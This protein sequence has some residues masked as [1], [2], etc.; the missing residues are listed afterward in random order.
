MTHFSSLRHHAVRSTKELLDLSR[1][2]WFLLICLSALKLWL[3]SHL[4]LQA[5]YAPHDNLRY[6]EMASEIWDFAPPFPYTQYTLMRQP[7]YPF[8]IRL[9]YVLGFSLR[10][11][12]ELL[13]IASGFFFAWS[14]YKYYHRKPVVVIFLSLYIFAPASF[15]WS[16]QTIQECL[17]LPLTTFVIS[18]LIHLVNSYSDRAKF[19]RWSVV[20]GISLAWY[21]NTRPEG[22]LI[23]SSFVVAYLVILAKAI[24]SKYRVRLAL[25]QIGYS[26]T[27]IIL[28]VVLTTVSLCSITYFKY[29]LFST[30]DLTAP[31]IKAVYSQLLSISPNRWRPMVPV[32]L[33]TRIEAYS[34]SPNFKKLANY[35]EGSGQAWFQFGCSIYQICDDYIG[36]LFVW[37]LRDAAADAGEYKSAT[38]TE[39]F[40]QQTTSELKLACNSGLLTCSKR[41]SLSS[42]AP[43]IR[44][45]YLK[46]FLISVGSTSARLINGTT[47][48][49]LGSGQEDEPTRK[50]YERI[51]REP[52]NFINQRNQSLNKLKDELTILIAKAYKAIFPIL[53]TSAI[54]GVVLQSASSLNYRNTIQEVPLYILWIILSYLLVRMLLV[55]YIDATSFP[56]D[57]RYLWPTAPLLLMSMSIG[58]SY[59]F[60]VV[61]LVRLF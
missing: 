36:G 21:W 28:P 11:S 13:Y 56:G 31:G 30:N 22:L 37:A 51:T 38:A 53:L 20:L 42:F 17:Y 50:K 58:T 3:T 1:S 26:V 57:F 19:L 6:A 8:F 7:G 24:H 49:N 29:G 12:Q 61:K 10:F 2:V 34:V 46:P 9:S 47:E 16:R 14:I 33:E 23:L 5:L 25:R 41:S 54:F 52:V 18:C 39:A 15:F 55:A 45:E 59:L 32:P 48:I 60:R 44:S 4:P 43:N 27:C 40:Y 35:L